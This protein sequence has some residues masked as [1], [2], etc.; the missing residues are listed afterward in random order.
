MKPNILIFCSWLDINSNVG[1]FFREQAELISDQYNPI[2][3]VF[4][5]K[6]VTKKNFNYFNIIGIEEKKTIEGLLVLEISYPYRDLFHYKI[7]EY[8]KK[9]TIK[10]LNCFLTNK[11]IDISFIHAQ[12]IFDAGIWAYHY[13]R[14][15]KIPYIITEH[16]QLSFYNVSK[17]KCN[18]VKKSLQNSA[19][20]LVVSNDKIR[21]FVANGLF[22][23]FVN[24]G[25][26]IN[27]KFFYEAENS[28]SKS[29]RFIT[30]GAFS[31]I[32][33]QITLLKALDLVDKQIN[34]RI[35]FVWIGQNSW[36]NNQDENEI[37]R[38]HV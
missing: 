4:K 6:T 25:N 18:L 23:D 20:N 29:V 24:I 16:N 36:G 9:L 3:V 19:R 14:Q 10:N 32:K 34:N 30:I 21:Q 15:F 26:L 11:K 2:L 22:F 17:E 5:Q 35:E 1:I 27:K 38:A 8:F 12:S 33:D 28:R 31:P 37:G 13:Y 7:N